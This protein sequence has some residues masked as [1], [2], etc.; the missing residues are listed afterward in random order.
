MFFVKFSFHLLCNSLLRRHRGDSAAP[1]RVQY[2]GRSHGTPEVERPDAMSILDRI[3]QR[4][5]TT[6]INALAFG[7]CTLRVNCSMN[8][9]DRSSGFYDLWFRSTAECIIKKLAVSW[10]SQ[11]VFDQARFPFHLSF[12]VKT[13]MTIR[14]RVFFSI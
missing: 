9:S 3:M 10:V 4:H 6:L 5:S 13:D 12:I 14:K 11:M 1:W 2:G 7:F 8:S